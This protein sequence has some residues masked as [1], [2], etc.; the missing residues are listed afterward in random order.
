M[1]IGFLGLGNMGRNLVLNL[2]DSGHEVVAWNRS[3]QKRNIARDQGINV[4]D[5]VAEL[6]KELDSEERKVIWLL[7]AAGSA[8]DHVLFDDGGIFDSLGGGDIVIEGA[9][10]H[11]MA[12]QDRAVMFAEKGISYLDVGI[13]GGVKGARDG[14][15]MMIGGD[16]ETFD[17]TEQLFKDST[18]E[19]G[20]GY[21]GDSG[22][23]HYV[24]MVHNAVEYGMMQAIAEGVNLVE[25]SDFDVDLA[26]MTDVWNHGSIIQ[27]NLVGYLN[28]ALQSDPGL[29][30]TDPVIGSLGTGR[31]A[32][33]DGMQ[34]GVPMN[35]IASAVFARYQSRDPESM[36]FKSVQAM[37]SVFGAHTSEE[38]PSD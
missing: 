10:S 12:S 28:Q 29:A 33:E 27:S 16:K 31:W 26:K 4:K 1:K 6:L 13:S 2:M 18:V 36:L 22:A 35:A 20:Y 34:R 21:F 32:V 7:V 25:S 8:V 9:N 11:Y 23:G 24:K 17:Y 5:T 30:K 14:A 3:E 37:R 38:R 15:C 19:N